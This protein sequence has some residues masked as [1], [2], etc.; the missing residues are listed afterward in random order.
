MTTQEYSGATVDTD[1]QQP[2]Q[3]D[4]P[5]ADDAEEAAIDA[6]VAGDEADPAPSTD[7][8]NYGDPVPGPVDGD[9]QQTSSEPGQ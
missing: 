1:P 9:P 8:V 7:Y 5:V 4:R 2:D 6:H 3:P